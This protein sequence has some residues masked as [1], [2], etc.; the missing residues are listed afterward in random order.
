MS[1]GKRQRRGIIYL[2]HCI[3]ENKDYVGQTR[4]SFKK[5]WHEHCHA[6]EKYGQRLAEG[7]RTSLSSI[8][9]KINELGPDAFETSILERP[10]IKDLNKRERYWI[11]EL[12]TRDPHGYNKTD[13]GGANGRIEWAE[14]DLDNIIRKYSDNV[15]ISQ[16]ARE[17]GCSRSTIVDVLCRCDIALRTDEENYA[18]LRHHRYFKVNE[19]GVVLEE[20]ETFSAIGRWAK[21][22]GYIEDKTDSDDVA[23]LPARYAILSETPWLGFMWDSTWT[24]N[25]KI[26][27]IQRNKEN[28]LY[29][30][31]IGGIL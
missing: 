11:A 16:L 30:P 28:K 26:E 12:G 23:G 29:S 2:I 9:E 15:S 20:Y 19:N 21:E 31:N 13:G 3:P 18:L 24:Q 22:Q 14:E 17:Y 8:D 4:R 1:Q 7:K 5:R 25:E 6:V 27:R 10:L